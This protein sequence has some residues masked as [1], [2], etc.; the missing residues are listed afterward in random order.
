MKKL[1][2]CATLLIFCF[3][4]S[5]VFAQKK[6][7]VLNHVAIYVVDLKKSTAFYQNILQIDTVPEPFHDGKHAWFKVGDHR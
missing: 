3:S 1:I 7:P 5:E 6:A 2:V 4:S